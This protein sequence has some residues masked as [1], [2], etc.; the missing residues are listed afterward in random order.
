MCTQNRGGGLT[1]LELHNL[2]SLLMCVITS[3]RIRCAE[4]VAHIEDMRNVYKSLF[5]SPEGKRSHRRPR[6]K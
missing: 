3:G 1:E 6:R 5:G 4:H 2:Y